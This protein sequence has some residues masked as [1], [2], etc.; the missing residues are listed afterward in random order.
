MH[1]LRSSSP[2]MDNDVDQAY[3]LGGG[4]RYAVSDK[5]DVR[6]DVRELFVPDRVRDGATSDYEVTAGVTWRF[7]GHKPAPVSAPE[8]APGP[9]DTDGDGLTDDIDRCPT[10]PE[11]KDGFQDEDGCPDPDNDNDGIPDV[12]DKCPDQPETKNGYQDEDG[13]PDQVIAELAGIGFELDS[14]KIDADSAP[15][16]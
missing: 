8:P 10:Q 16:L 5:L 11:D 15:I 14:A 12:A 6:F 4:V 1:V 9:V 7:G 3:H 2:Q 13:C